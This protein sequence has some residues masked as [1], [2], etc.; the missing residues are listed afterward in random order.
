MGAWRAGMPFLFL[1]IEKNATRKIGQQLSFS[2]LSAFVSFLEQ[3]YAE[4]AGGNAAC[5][6]MV[7]F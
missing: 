3:G 6:C 5:L 1:Y 4:P 7:W 2:H